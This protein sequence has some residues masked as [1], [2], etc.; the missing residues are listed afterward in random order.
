MLLF[1]GHRLSLALVI[2]VVNV[3][4][5]CDSVISMA[6]V[7]EIYYLAPCIKCLGVGITGGPSVQSKYKKTAILPFISFSIRSLL[8]FRRVQATTGKVLINI[9]VTI[10]AF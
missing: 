2:H 8:P 1:T 4:D 7:P 9:N 5:V 6:F 3:C 10:Y